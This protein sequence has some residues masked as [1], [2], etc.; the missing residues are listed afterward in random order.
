MHSDMQPTAPVS[1][2]NPLLH[3]VPVEVLHLVCVLSGVLGELLVFTASLVRR[4]ANVQR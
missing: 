4:R 2:A 3:V 1:E